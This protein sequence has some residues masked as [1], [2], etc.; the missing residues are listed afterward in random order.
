[1]GPTAS[2]HTAGE[3][4]RASSNLHI[5]GPLGVS[6]VVVLRAQ[7]ADIMRLAI[8]IPGNDFQ[9]LGAQSKDFVPPIKPQQV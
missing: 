1:M 8:V 7:G 3:I 9:E 4:W 5:I 6:V 2:V